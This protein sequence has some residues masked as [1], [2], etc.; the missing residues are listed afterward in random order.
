MQSYCKPKWLWFTSYQSRRK[1]PHSETSSETLELQRAVG[2]PLG[3]HSLLISNNQLPAPN[4]MSGNCS[5]SQL[6]PTT[7]Q[8]ALAEHQEDNYTSKHSYSLDKV[9]GLHWHHDKSASYNCKEQLP[10]HLP[11]LKPTP[12]NKILSW[13]KTSQT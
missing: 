1:N 12:E 11:H 3:S 7:K 10:Q 8:S 6:L 2:E 5:I 4:R 13:M 9:H